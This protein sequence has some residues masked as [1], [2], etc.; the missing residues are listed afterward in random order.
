MSKDKEDS[1]EYLF[2]LPNGNKLTKDRVEK[3]ISALHRACGMKG[4]LHSY[5]RGGITHYC[6]LGVP[7]RHLQII[8]GHSNITTTELY[9]RPDVEKVI[10]DQQNW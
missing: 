6:N 8:A 10:T 1:Q 2:L 5:R 3:R 7:L 9:A 4:A